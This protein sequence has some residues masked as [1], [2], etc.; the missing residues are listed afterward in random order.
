MFDSTEWSTN[1]INNVHSGILA[2]SKTDSH[3]RRRSYTKLPR[4]ESHIKTLFEDNE[5]INIF[6]L[7]RPIKTKSEVLKFAT[8]LFQ[9]F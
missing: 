5:L 7:F 4:R 3:K 9:V 6:T 8:M 1:Y 2:G